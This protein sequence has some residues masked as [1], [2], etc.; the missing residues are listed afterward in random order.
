MTTWKRYEQIQAYR[1]NNVTLNTIEGW[2]AG[3]K[4]PLF[5]NGYCVL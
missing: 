4:T 1:P 5:Y 3:I 2:D